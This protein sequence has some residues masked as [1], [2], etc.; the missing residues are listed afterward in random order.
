MSPTCCLPVQAALLHCTVSHCLQVE[1][2]LARLQRRVRSLSDSAISSD[3]TETE[4]TS[5]S[6]RNSRLPVTD[7]KTEGVGPDLAFYNAA[8]AH[9]PQEVFLARREDAEGPRLLPY[10]SGKRREGQQ[11]KS[12]EDSGN[13]HD[14]QWQ[15]TCTGLQE[16]ERGPSGDTPGVKQTHSGETAAPRMS[17]RGVGDATS[18]QLAAGAAVKPQQGA[19]HADQ[20]T[21]SQ[22][23][24]AG[25]ASQSERRAVPLSPESTCHTP[26]L[27]SEP[28]DAVSPTR[29]AFPELTRLPGR[30]P[31]RVVDAILSVQQS[32]PAAAFAS[33]SRSLRK[34]RGLLGRK[35]KSLSS[36][37]DLAAAQERSDLEENLLEQARLIMQVARVPSGLDLSTGGPAGGGFANAAGEETGYDQEALAV[38]WVDG[39]FHPAKSGQALLVSRHPPTPAEGVSHAWLVSAERGR[40]QT[41]GED[42]LSRDERLS[43]R[44]GPLPADLVRSLSEQAAGQAVRASVGGRMQA[45]LTDGSGPRPPPVP[46]RADPDA[47]SVTSITSVYGSSTAPSVSELSD[48]SYGQTEGGLH[49]HHPELLSADVDSDRLLSDDRLLSSGELEV[50]AINARAAVIRSR[51][52]TDTESAERALSPGEEI[53]ADI[54]ARQTAVASPT[55]DNRAG[56]RSSARRLDQPRIRGSSPRRCPPSGPD[57]GVSP[58]E[59]LL[60]RETVQRLQRAGLGLDDGEAVED[61]LQTGACEDLESDGLSAGQ[62]RMLLTKALSTSNLARGRCL[63]EGDE[64]QSLAWPVR[65]CVCIPVQTSADRHFVSVFCMFCITVGNLIVSM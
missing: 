7:G 27:V 53:L 30:F 48:A 65:T 25:S 35:T 63:S 16:E 9:S 58:Q 61:L 34:R 44:S 14:D 17:P 33:H 20:S 45:M 41:V 18:A 39:H 54:L 8:I 57:G 24:R 40:A 5:V 22:E 31:E 52:H 42:A 10:P 50:A 47:E 4:S 62:R 60:P 56:D 15:D 43:V 37:A 6:P 2:K 32:W 36:L 51:P 38:D 1:R 13:I 59:L 21:L 28:G 55:T 46:Q 12:L 19:G 64:R 3:F 29:Q 23:G 11:G 49:Y 26:A